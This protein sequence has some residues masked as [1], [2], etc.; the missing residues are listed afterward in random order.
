M[1]DIAERLHSRYNP[2][3]E[4]RRYIDALKI[5]DDVNCFILV[6]PGMGYMIPV[7]R[8]NRPDSKIIVLHA[9][10]CFRELP[11]AVNAEAV[12]YHDSGHSVQEFLEAEV[13]SCA[14]VRIVEWRPGLNVY[15]EIVLELVRESADFVKRL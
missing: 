12:W 1:N 10:T 9:D 3:V 14:R 5:N 8:E 2:Q 13:P 11:G 4:A 15:G 6:E 7:L